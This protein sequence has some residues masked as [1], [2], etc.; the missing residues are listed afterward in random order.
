MGMALSWWKRS[1]IGAGS[2]GVLTRPAIG[3][4]WDSHK[5]AVAGIGNTGSWCP[6]KPY[7]SIRLAARLAKGCVDE[8]ARRGKAGGGKPA[9]APGKR[10]LTNPARSEEHTSEL[11]SLRHL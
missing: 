2:M 8:R 5:G 1:W 11:Q 9:V 4:R 6:R 7:M 10:G 3:W